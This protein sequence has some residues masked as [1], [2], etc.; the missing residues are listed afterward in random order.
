MTVIGN[1]WPKYQ[2]GFNV[3]L[4]YKS[5]D[6][7]VNMI[8][9]AKRDVL[10]ET[11]VFEQSFI[12]DFNS[13]YEIFGASF[14][15]ENGLTDQPRLGFFNDEGAFIQDPNGNYR[16]YSDYFIEDASYFK[17]KDI[18]LG[19]SLPSS[20]LK[21]LRLENLRVYFTGQNLLTFTKFSG[22][23]PEFSNGVKNYGEYNIFDFPQT[24][25]F[26]FGV[27]LNF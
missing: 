4:E 11:K 5:F 9:I 17:V 26:S 10:N 22:L 6:L 14:F 7:S 21:R 12:Q 15:L 16:Y 27:E 13:T 3:Q 8:G 1:P 18:T 20:F 23:D 24:R 2:Y 25:L 19:Y